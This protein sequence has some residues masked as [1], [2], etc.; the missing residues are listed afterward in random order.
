MKIAL[1]ANDWQVKGYWS[2]DPLLA[3]SMETGIDRPGVTDWM[4]AT[5]PGGIHYDLYRAGLIENPFRDDAS[6]RCEWVENRWW[7]YRTSFV[8]PVVEEGHT[9]ELTFEGLDYDVSVYLNRKLIGEHK[10]MFHHCKIDITEYVKS[11]DQQELKLMFK[12]VPDEYAIGKTSKTTTQ[13]SRFSYNWDFSTRLINIGVWDALYIKVHKGLSIEDLAVSTST[14]HNNGRV[15]LQLDIV[16]HRNEDDGAEAKTCELRVSCYSPNNEIVCTENVVLSK[17]AEHVALTLD[18]PDPQ[19]WYPL[20]YGDQPLYKLQVSI[21]YDN[22]ILDEKSMLVGIRDLAYEQN[23]NSPADALPYTVKINGKRIYLKG[24]NITPLDMMYGNV[25]LEQYEWFVLMLKSANINTVRIWGGGLIE[26]EAFYDLCDHHG[27][28]IWQDFIQSG[29]GIESIPAKTPEYLD[30]LKTSAIAAI[31]RRR[32]HV[33][34]FMWTGGNELMTREKVPISYNDDNIAMLKSLVETY[35]PQRLFLPSTPSGPCVIV[36]EVAEAHDVHGHWTYLGNPEHYALYNRANHLFHSEF[37]VNGMSAMK[38]I[39][40]YISQDQLTMDRIENGL[41]SR[42]H[43]GEWWNSVVRDQELFGEISDVSSLADCSQW[44]QAEGLRYILESDLR[45]KFKNSG[46]LIW[47]FNEPW[48]N[49]FCTTI[50]D[51]FGEAKMAYYW[52]KD[53]YRPMHASLMYE[54]LHY[55]M[56]QRFETSVYAHGTQSQEV[57]VAAQVL[58]DDGTILS[59]YAFSGHVGDNAAALMGNIDFDITVEHGK[60]FYIRLVIDNQSDRFENLYIFS[61]IKDQPYAP[62]LL[63]KGGNLEVEEK[64]EWNLIKDATF[65]S[66]EI[67]QRHFIVTN[68]GKQVLL[69][70]HPEE[71]TDAYWMVSEGSYTSLFPGESR[72][73][74]TTCVR[75]RS[76]G[77][78]GSDP[79]T[80]G[81]PVVPEIKFNWFNHR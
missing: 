24:V 22:N 40:K 35:D 1:S 38:S 54:K 59:E 19:L 6:I 81:E 4:P 36:D 5:V 43:G 3:D 65:P 67:Y 16:S 48:P 56:G 72:E 62:A 21:V 31:K 47:Q 78:M 12:G 23:E 37:G 70:V 26:K 69:H 75:K 29:A 10:G 41:I 17:R 51:Y 57:E 61:T 9:Y 63:L 68:T 8:I 50:C 71:L 14:D 74:A 15:N 58:T 30:L 34:L 18:V 2:W 77:F 32:N 52:T 66:L 25:T 39:R 45:K 73:V 53:A 42:H 80:H 79:A 33:S 49:I 27:I 64:G 20:G 46:S 28:L 60:L 7:V 11:N 44:I 55:E 13:K 76:G